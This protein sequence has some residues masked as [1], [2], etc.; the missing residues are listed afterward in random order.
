[1]ARLKPCPYDGPYESRALTRAIYYESRAL[2]RAIY[3]ASHCLAAA[4]NFSKSAS[5]RDSL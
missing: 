3:S 1:M 2:T 5:L 4:L